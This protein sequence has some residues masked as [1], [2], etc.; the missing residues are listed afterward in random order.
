MRVIAIVNQK[1]GVGKTSLCFHVSAAFAAI[2][3]RVVLI[4]N[5]PQASLTQGWIGPQATEELPPEATLAAAYAEDP[6]D[7]AVLVR[8]TDVPRVELIAGSWSLG[9]VNVSLPMR[10][11]WEHQQAIAGLVE[12]LGGDRSNGVVLIDCPPNL[13]VLAWAALV[14]ADLVLVPV[15]AEDYGSQGIAAIERFCKVARQL[16]RGLPDPV[17]VLNLVDRRCKLPRVYEESLRSTYG[18][19]VLSTIVPRAVDLP[20]AVHRRVPVERHRPHGAAALAIRSLAA[21]LAELIGLET[22]TVAIG[23]EAARG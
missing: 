1:G 7:V 16:N 12:D 15:Q 23:K 3:P 13:H 21:E 22:A 2:C 10:A 17:F 8:P 14:A 4:D 11:P 5:D 19:R 6:H 18:P 9:D 20:E